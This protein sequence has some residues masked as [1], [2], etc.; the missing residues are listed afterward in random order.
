MLAFR[1]WL[2]SHEADRTYYEQTKRELAQRKW[3]YIQH[4]AN[5]KSGVVEAIL[6]Q[7]LPGHHR[8]H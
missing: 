5:T 6:A 2:R 7:A 8:N 3:K 4:Y 1:D